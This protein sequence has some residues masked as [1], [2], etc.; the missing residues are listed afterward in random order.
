MPYPLF[1]VTGLTAPDESIGASSA[2]VPCSPGDVFF[3]T[4]TIQYLSGGMQPRLYINFYD[5]SGSQI[6][7]LHGSL[8]ISQQL[9]VLTDNGWHI[10]FQSGPA[11]PLAATVN[12]GT[13]C[14]Y[15]VG[16]TA[17]V[18]SWQV[19]DCRV[20]QNGNPLYLPLVNYDSS[21]TSYS[22]RQ[23]FVFPLYYLSLFTSQYKNAQNLY[24]WAAALI[25]PVTDLLACVQQL[26]QAFA[27]PLTT[28]APRGSRAQYAFRPGGGQ[29]LPASGAPVDPVV[30][31]SGAQLDIIGTIVGASRRLPFQPVTGSPP[32]PVSPILDDADYL[33]LIQAKIAQNQW[34][35]QVGSLYVL[36]G[37]LFPGGHITVLDN[38]NMTANIILSGTFTPIALQMIENDMIIPRPQGV[39]YIYGSPL[40]PV[41]GADVDNS[42]IAGADVGYAT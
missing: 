2:Q 20:A 40:L 41:F 34:D 7:I 39:E 42:L 24:A 25:Q 11:P 9:A 23:Q 30:P 5:A 27:L 18:T 3:L 35:G 8:A 31:A 14:Q 10:Q 17:S 32:V 28:N 16:H 37:Y 22:L 6:T 26:Y 1:N 13:D 4:G 36:W 15:V 21:L 33:T 29:T 19:S 12:V 38:Q